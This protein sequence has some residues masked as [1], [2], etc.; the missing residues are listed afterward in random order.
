MILNWLVSTDNRIVFIRI[1]IATIL[2]GT[3]SI[4]YLLNDR[5]K[6]VLYFIIVI[7]VVYLSSL[8]SIFVNSY[9]DKYKKLINVLYIVTDVFISTLVITVTGGVTSPFI[10]LYALILIHVN[11]LFSNR[12]VSYILSVVLGLLFLLIIVTKPR[13]FNSD[14]S[15]DLSL[16]ASFDIDQTSLVYTYF[17]LAGF[18]LVSMLSGL[19]SERTR[20]ARQELGESRKNLNILKNMNDNILRSLDSGVITLDQDGKI[21]SANRKAVDILGISESGSILNKD[22]A[23]YI[24]GFELSDLISKR[25]EQIIYTNPDDVQLYLGF[26]SSKLKDEN[27]E[28]I[29]YVLIFQDLTEMKELEDKLRSAEKLAILGQLASGL[30]HEIRNPLSAISGALEI[31]SSEVN[32]SSSNERLLNVANQEIERMRLLVDDFSIMTH[33]IPKI[34][35]EVNIDDILMDIIET[36]TKT[37]K[38]SNIEVISEISEDLYVVADSFRL[39]QVFWNLL[40]NSMQSITNDGKINIKAY[41]DNETVIIKITDDGSGINQKDLSRIFE[42]FFTTKKS[43]TGLGLAIVQKIIENYNGKIDV[44]STEEVGSTFIISFPLSKD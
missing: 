33:P 27:N 9:S 16:H 8:L 39:K 28:D 35:T 43:G 22:F 34:D 41:N 42:P 30:T 20:L 5:V 1:I 6:I 24:K 36:F 23:D 12:L 37:I 26:S 18:L 10:F 29:G 38:R 40:I 4:I 44:I 7:L 14:N 25:R 11:I 2:F 32:P 15:Y 19:L 21:L 17:N 31:L 13:I 3:S